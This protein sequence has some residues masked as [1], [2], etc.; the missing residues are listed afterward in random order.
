M[1]RGAYLY[2]LN[3]AICLFDENKNVASPSLQVTFTATITST[4]RTY[5]YRALLFFDFAEVD[6]ALKIKRYREM[7]D[8]ATL[9]RILKTAK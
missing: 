8:T 7:P 1:A 4:G 6:G 5:P 9:S 2:H 3:P